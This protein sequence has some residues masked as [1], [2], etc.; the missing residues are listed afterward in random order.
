MANISIV[1][2]DNSSVVI[3]DVDSWHPDDMKGLT[4]YKN[5]GD[6]IYIKRK[7]F[8][9]FVVF[10]DEFEDEDEYTPSEGEIN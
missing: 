3:E 1:L 7:S 5:N 8:Q 4:L 2:K 10:Q 9:W 6:I